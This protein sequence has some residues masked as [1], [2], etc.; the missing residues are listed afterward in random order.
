MPFSF[1]GKGGCFSSPLPQ[2]AHLPSRTEL[3]VMSPSLPTLIMSQSLNRQHE[4]PN[5]LSHWF[6][7]PRANEGLTYLSIISVM[8][9]PWSAFRHT[10]ISISGSPAQNDRH[11]RLISH[12]DFPGNSRQLCAC[13]FCGLRVSPF[14]LAAWYG[15]HGF[16]F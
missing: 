11:N 4:G 9:R 15:A 8:S 3:A 13:S 5:R 16:Q 14:S 2:P 7:R 1:H 10:T 6:H 12:P